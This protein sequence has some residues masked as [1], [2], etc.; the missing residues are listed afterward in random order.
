LRR[1]LPE[2]KLRED[3][4]INKELLEKL[5][6]TQKDM[7]EALKMVRPSAMR[8]VLVEVPSTKWEDIGGLSPVKQELIEAVE[9]PLK[10]P[11]S[12]RRLGVKPPRGIMLYGPPGTGKTMLGKAVATES[13]ANF[14]LVKGP[15]LLSKWVGESEKAVRKIFKK[16]RQTSPTIIFFDEIDSL[17]P[18]RGQSSDSDVTGRVVNQ[19]LTEMDGLEELR[20][21]VVIAATNRPDIL[22]SA[23]LRPGRFDR[24][25]YAPVP[26]MQARFDVF[27]VHTKKMKIDFG[28]LSDYEPGNEASSLFPDLKK[29]SKRDE[30]SVFL[31]Y[32]AEK[33]DGYVGADIEAVCREAAMLALRDNMQATSVKITYFDKALDKV[34]PSVTKEIEETYKAMQDSFRMAK[35]KEMEKPAYMG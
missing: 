8:E 15:E 29:K 27:D 22:D 16:A 13:Q 7:Y 1:L 25:I 3:E 18:K 24:I 32:M 12:F 20:D 31:A 2:I 14:I 10:N 21:V 6:I 35:A 30:R 26:D 17:A 23:L 33:T 34:K 28:G 19:L 11:M 9:W 4:P 5:K